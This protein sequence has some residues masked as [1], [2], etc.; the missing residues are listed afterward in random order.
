MCQHIKS[1]LHAHVPKYMVPAALPFWSYLKLYLVR[2]IKNNCVIFACRY[3]RELGTL[4]LDMGPG[5]AGYHPRKP[6]TLCTIL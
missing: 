5:R 1:V 6:N 2:P 3:L 4:R